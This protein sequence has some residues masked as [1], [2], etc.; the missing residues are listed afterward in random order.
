MAHVAQHRTTQPR[1]GG[2]K[3][4]V[5][6]ADAGVVIGRDALF[7]ELRAADLLVKRKR[8][9]TNTTYSQHTYAVAPN[10]FKT[11]TITAPGQAVVSDITY[12]RLAPDT[13]AYLFLAS[14][15]FS[16]KIVG[17]HL[18]RDLSHYGALQALR[19]AVLEVRDVVGLVHHSDRGCQ[20]C[21]H[22]FLQELAESR[23][24]SSMTDGNHCYQNAIAERINGILKDEFDLD[25]IFPSF[26]QAHQAVA[27]AIHAYNHHRLHGSLKLQTP[28]QVFQHAA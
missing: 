27:R 26:A 19:G 3:L 7:A 2:K 15:V 11:M 20:Y 6:L 9:G 22:D 5:H 17:W 12:L 16:R 10:R 25:A 24:L 18:S 1:V 23:I 13:F 8:R 14:D 28:A 21:C 4:H